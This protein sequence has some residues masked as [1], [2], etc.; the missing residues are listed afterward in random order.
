VDA[1]GPVSGVV[2]RIPLPAALERVRRDHD[3]V[4]A[5]AAPAHV[6][7]L[8]PFLPATGLTPDLRR[9][10]GEIARTVTPFDVH[11]ENV[12]RFPGVVYLAPEPASPFVRL[13]QSIVAR[14]PDHPPYGG[15]YPEVVPHLTLAEAADSR[16][17]AVVAAASP[18]LPFRRHVSTIELLTQD[19][20]GRWRCHW[21]LPLGI[22]P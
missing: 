6:T 15:A 2:V 14:F 4:T 12:G 5:G 1:T 11:F 21:R 13:T 19:H 17:D 18:S 20:A 3:L 16:L 9:E 8:F 22:R 7:L 10:L